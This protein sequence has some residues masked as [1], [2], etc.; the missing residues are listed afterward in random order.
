MKNRKLNILITGVGGPTPRSYARALKLDQEYDYT[1][2]GTDIHS[3][4]IGL[5]QKDLFM[6]S[7]ITPRSSE[8]DYWAVMERIISHKKI[9]Y[10]VILPEQE[11][12]TWSQRQK[13][14]ILP[15][16]SLIPD[17]NCVDTMLDKALLCDILND[18]GLVARSIS[19]G[20]DEIDL[21]M[22]I[23]SIVNYPFW[24]R[25]TTGSSGLGSLKISSFEELERW[26]LINPLV[27]RFI[28][29]DFLPGRNYACKLIY[30]EGNLVR[31]AVGER[32]EYVM[33]KIVPSGITGNT[34][35]GKLINNQAV[36]N[37]ARNA[38]EMVFEKTNS[39]KHGFF[40]VDLKE[41]SDGNPKVT[42]INIRHVA[43]TSVFAMA[44]ANLCA[45]TI[46]LL[47]ATST[48]SEEFKLYVFPEEYLFIRDVDSLPILLSK[49]DLL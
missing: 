45:D 24:V 19:F 1:L 47:D 2:Y 22:R 18:T 14:D 42:E 37:V 40:T 11:V 7:F 30:Y 15:C 35:F 16:R 28:A 26:I 41:D 48:Y 17:Y 25:S 8:Q 12:K 36:F 46:K 9:D 10:A 6:E 27:S 29:S 34:S 49:D 32:I 44:G 38:T 23:E 21:N 13:D 43:F 39:V 3:H 20:R 33:S 5:Y 4:A 31:A